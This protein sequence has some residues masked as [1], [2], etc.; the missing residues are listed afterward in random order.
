MVMNDD[1]KRKILEAEYISFDIFDTLVIRSCGK[2]DNVFRILGQRLGINSEKFK[3][4]R[5]NA[6]K[7][8]RKLCNHSEI[9]LTDIYMSFDLKI[10][11]DDAVKEEIDTEKAVCIVNPEMR[12]LYQFCQDKGKKIILTSDMYLPQYV[13]ENILHNLDYTGYEKI[14]LSSTL[15]KKKSSGELFSYI[16]KQLSVTARK[17]L[18]I[19]D[20]VKSDYIMP[21]L[22]GINSYHYKKIPC[23]KS[24]LNHLRTFFNSRK[25]DVQESYFYDFGYKV[26]GPALYGYVKWLHRRLQ[27]LG[28]SRVYFMAREGQIIKKAFDLIEENHYEEHYIYVSRRSLTIPA[29]SC[30]SSME[31]FLA[32]RPIYGRVTVENQIGKLGLEKEKF[33]KYTWFNPQKLSSRFLDLDDKTKNIILRDMFHEAK[34]MGEM[35]IDNVVRYLKQEH[36][37]GKIA[38]VDLGWNGS[39]QRALSYLLEKNKTSVNMIGF[40]LAQ[41]DEFYRYKNSIVNNGFLFNYGQGNIKKRMALNSGVSFLEFLF[42]ADHGTTIKYSNNNGISRPVLDEYEY[43]NVYNIIKECQI[44]ALDFIRDFKGKNVFCNEES[45]YFQPMYELLQNPDREFLQHFGDVSISDFNEKDLFL[46]KEEKFLPLKKFINSF[47]DSAW[48]TAY[49][50]RNLNTNKAFWI[51]FILRVIFNR[52][53]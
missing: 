1:L 37:T 23:N 32:L 33:K 20:N 7:R 27:E 22:Y 15:Q 46:A 16:L 50:K 28:I 40:F 31:D 13:I 12:K 48:K 10:D 38:I 44:G 43:T 11:I 8:V 25:C 26:F 30:V 41:R 36:M 4:A 3:Q 6:E 39:M 49:L 35:E 29:I 17:I 24:C 52:R 18:H 34:K 2:P 9:S 42:S 47:I 14:F 5:I 53:K 21:R 51:Y 19:G 45:L